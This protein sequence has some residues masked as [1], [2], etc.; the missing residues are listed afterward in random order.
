MLDHI[1]AFLFDRE[2]RAA[3]GDGHH[4]VDELHLAAAALMIEA[5]RLDGSFS[6]I[7]RR[8]VAGALK[9]RFGLSESEIASVIEAAE[10]AA[11]N[12]VEIY[13]FTS[14]IVRHFDHEERVAMIEMLWGVV[15]ADGP[16]DAYEANLLRRV[17]GLLYVTDRESGAARK[18]AAE[19]MG[20]AGTADNP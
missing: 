16:P 17:A 8:H 4:S 14:R 15:L 1:K 3:A 5:A 2:G 10:A 18:R 19:R 11:E 12:A 20:I 7:E 13:R 9:R 6:E